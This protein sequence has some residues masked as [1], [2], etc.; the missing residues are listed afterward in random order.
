MHTGSCQCGAVKYR[1]DAPIESLTHCHCSMCRKVHGAA[2]ATYASVPLEHFHLIEGKDQLGVY[3]SSPAVT[4]T[5]C[6]HCGSNLQFVDNHDHQSLG[7]AVGSL[8]SPL[9]APPQSHIFV[10]SKADWY[11]IRDGLPQHDADA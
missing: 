8:D 7:V 10:G 5:F 3:H 2:F 11:E 1:I 9:P 6:K 4:R